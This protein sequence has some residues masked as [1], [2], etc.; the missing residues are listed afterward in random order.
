MS[1]Q[2]YF[3]NRF[4]ERVFEQYEKIFG[5]LSFSVEKLFLGERMENPGSKIFVMQ[6]FYYFHMKKVLRVIFNELLWEIADYCNDEVWFLKK[7]IV[8]SFE[9]GCVFYGLQEKFE[10]GKNVIYWEYVYA[11]KTNYALSIKKFIDKEKRR[12]NCKDYERLIKMIY[13]WI[14]RPLMIVQLDRDVTLN[15]RRATFF[16]DFFEEYKCFE[17]N[18][19]RD[20]ESFFRRRQREDNDFQ[21]EAEV[22]RQEVTHMRHIRNRQRDPEDTDSF[23][24]EDTETEQDFRNTFF[25]GSYPHVFN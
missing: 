17:V 6:D 10:Q 2:D 14:D 11:P 4:Q 8:W 18:N 12:T 13:M 9:S 25:N 23:S 16:R 19:P 1:Y 21:F 5:P 7:M 24:S 3:M 20:V 22:D 15:G